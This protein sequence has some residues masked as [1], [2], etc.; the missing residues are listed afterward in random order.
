[1]KKRIHIIGAGVSGLSAACYLAQMG[2]DVTIFEKNDQ[3]GGRAQVW[4]Q[5]G[6]K[7]D[8]GPT[9]YWMPDVFEKF[10]ADFGYSPSDFFSLNRLDPGYSIYFDKGKRLSISASLNEIYDLFESE[11]KGSSM[12]LAS[13]LDM[14][15]KNYDIA[16]K[17]LV[18]QPGL[19]LSELI[20]TDTVL[21]LDQFFKS[22]RGVV[23]SKIK[24]S[25]LRKILEFPVLFLGAKPS[26]TP[27]FYSFMNHADFALGTW[28][29]IGGMSEVIKGIV[30]LT[31][32]LGV[33]ILYNQHIS[34][35]ATN[36]E[37]KVVGINIGDLLEPCEVV[38]SGADYAHTEKLLPPHLRQYSDRYWDSR[39]MAPSSLLYYVA[40]DKK[41]IN[42]DHHT[43]FFDTDFD[44]HAHAIYDQPRWPE[45]PMFYANFPS[46]TDVSF[47]P[48]NKECGTFLIPIAPDLE[49]SEQTRCF[50]FEKIIDRLEHLTGQSIKDSIL[51]YRSYCVTDFKNDYNSFKGNAYGLANTL[52]QTAYFRPNLR[53]RKVKNLYFTGQLTVPGPGVPPALISGNIVSS[54]ICSDLKNQ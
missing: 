4:S 42:L 1:M 3:P 51:F 26:S 16:I 34:G 53:S 39:T 54:L 48:Q 14:A 41:L 29:P 44:N 22:V 9:W 36:S 46:I 23:R 7:F 43:L 6:F 5:D 38:L 18:Y 12:H 8:M 10:F 50:Y 45:S 28:H 31:K 47:A 20:S 19:S 17:N 33:K 52:K 2:Y 11:E 13:F 37:G 35:I 49:D 40:F 21:R 24:S 30:K 15:Q 25:R 32:Q 27:A